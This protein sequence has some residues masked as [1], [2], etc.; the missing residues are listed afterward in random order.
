MRLLG[1][2]KVNELSP[3]HVSCQTLLLVSLANS[4]QINTRLV[5][6]E[7]YDGSANISQGFFGK[8]KAKL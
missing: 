2:E 8:A 4:L 7:I 6:N 5:E 1:V 3:Q